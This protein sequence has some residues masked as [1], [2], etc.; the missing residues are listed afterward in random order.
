M[1]SGA[2]GCED[3]AAVPSPRG[4]ALVVDDQA[5][6]RSLLEALLVREGFEVVHATDGAHGT[7]LFG[8]YGADI[9]F[10]DVLMPVMDGYEAARRIKDLAGD[11][12]VPVIFITALSD[13]R[14]LARCVEAGGD[15]FLSKPFD[16]TIL[17]ARIHAAERV[18][19]LHRELR[20]RNTELSRLHAHL[21]REQEIAERI[22]SAAVNQ[23]NVALDRIRTLLRPAATFSGDVL[24]TARRPSGEL[25]V[26][27]GDF[28]GHGLTAAVGA[29][30]VSEVFR[31]MTDKGFAAAD[32]LREIDRKLTTLLPPSMFMA[33]CFVTLNPAQG[34]AMIWNGGMPDLLVVG[35]HGRIR[36]R[37][38]SMEHPLGIE[39]E[40]DSAF[41]PVHVELGH[42]DTLLLLSDGLLDARNPA[43]DM[44]G[45]S[46]LEASI[47]VDHAATTAFDRVAIAL[48]RFCGSD[49]PDDDITLVAIPCAPEMAGDAARAPEPAVLPQMCA[50]GC[51]WRWTIEL[52]ADCLRRI[53][54]VPVA[55]AQLQALRPLDR[56]REALYTVLSELF[57]NALEH[58]ILELDPAIKLRR[59]GFGAYYEERQRRL[60]ELTD[61][62]IRIDLINV[63]DAAGGR[64][65]IHFQDSGKGFRHESV[66]RNA[67]GGAGGRAGQGIQV[68]LGLCESL[69]Y[70]GTGNRV[71]AVYAWEG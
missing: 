43:G 25:N 46:R 68:L 49:A 41:L 19:D 67:S 15:D 5:S 12:F 33:A 8:R 11:S 17:R 66:C 45:R 57:S 62:R 21:Q 52:D 64:L 20:R 60:S 34:Q 4:R 2:A 13:K 36:R 35:A 51:Q 1:N 44:F 70:Q 16:A 40:Q 32:I 47:E 7:E 18:R 71:E 58:G 61:G 23:P 27:L 54:P 3:D 38:A 69:H 53:D 28:T 55:M 37:V 56:H 30:P 39:G 14:S 9:V 26:L 65:L 6:N 48:S 31:A 59:D 50:T 29:L 10:L 42:D 63:Y 22:Y 24:L